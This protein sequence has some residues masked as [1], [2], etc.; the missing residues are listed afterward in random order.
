MG[1]GVPAPMLYGDDPAGERESAGQ[2]TGHRSQVTGH[3]IRA[4]DSR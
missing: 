2:V 4:G 1:P 3:G